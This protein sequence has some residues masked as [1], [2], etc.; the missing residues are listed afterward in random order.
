MNVLIDVCICVVSSGVRQTQGRCDQSPCVGS[1]PKEGKGR[2]QQLKI[3]VQE[4]R[5]SV[6]PAILRDNAT[7]MV[8]EKRRVG[9]ID[10]N[11]LIKINQCHPLKRDLPIPRPLPED[12]RNGAW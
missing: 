8:V 4:A 6:S 5:P 1:R 11:P 10:I 2:K 12:L 7:T 9:Y 3:T